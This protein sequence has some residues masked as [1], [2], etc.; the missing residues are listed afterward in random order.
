MVK[1]E[2]FQKLFVNIRNLHQKLD[3][4]TKFQKNRPIIS[5]T[6]VYRWGHLTLFL[7]FEELLFYFL[8]AVYIRN[9]YIMRSMRPKKV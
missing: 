1:N 9:F 8:S 2:F 4:L 7:F 6:E 5:L 3:I